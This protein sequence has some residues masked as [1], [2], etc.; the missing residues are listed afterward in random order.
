MEFHHSLFTFSY[1]PYDRNSGGSD[2]DQSALLDTQLLKLHGNLT[3]QERTKTYQQ[4]CKNAEGILLCT[5]VGQFCTIHGSELRERSRH[6]HA[7]ARARARHSIL[8]LTCLC[9]PERG[10]GCKHVEAHFL[11]GKKKLCN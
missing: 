8:A 4:F 5:D 7:R 9:G 6:V 3:Q 11:R 1:W 10:G 2:R